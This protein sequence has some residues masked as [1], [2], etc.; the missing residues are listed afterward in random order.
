MRQTWDLDDISLEGC[1]GSLNG[2]EFLAESSD[3]GLASKRIEFPGQIDG[4]AKDCVV[5]FPGKYSHEWDRAVRLSAGG[6]GAVSLAC[7]FLTNR[8]SALGEHCL[9]PET[10][11]ECWCQAIYGP[12]P[13][14][15]YLSVVEFDPH[16][17]GQ[18]WAR[19]FL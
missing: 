7:V 16:D 13:A 18:Q 5:S 19:F 9:N 8:N 1:R 10:P 15:T 14:S 3:F 11:G 6:S 4:F 12:V 2:L 17:N